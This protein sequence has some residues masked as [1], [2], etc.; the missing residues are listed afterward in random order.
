[1]TPDPTVADSYDRLYAVY[2]E[3]YPRLK[4][5]FAASGAV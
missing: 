1:M 4:E 5:V 2:R 3:L